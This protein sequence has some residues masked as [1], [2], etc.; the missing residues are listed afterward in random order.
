MVGYALTDSA[1]LSAGTAHATTRCACGGRFA[2]GRRAGGR[3]TE[4]KGGV[5]RCRGGAE[6]RGG[7]VQ[8]RCLGDWEAMHCGGRVLEGE[9][10]DTQ[11]L[12]ERRGT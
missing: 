3:G 6:A 8:R 5:R 1:I 11:R 4:E 9:H 10:E 2:W 12:Q 7:A